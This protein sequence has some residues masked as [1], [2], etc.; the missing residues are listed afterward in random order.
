MWH[1]ELTI[2]TKISNFARELGISK[3][4]IDRAK[5]D[6]DKLVTQYAETRRLVLKPESSKLDN[7]LS[8]QEFF[9]WGFN[10]VP[11]FF[12]LVLSGQK[13]VTFSFF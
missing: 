12:Q 2:W 5:V 7:S 9:R 11:C 3:E 1:T 8:M 10:Y 13:I 4:V 6:Y